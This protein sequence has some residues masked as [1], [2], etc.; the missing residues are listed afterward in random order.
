MELDKIDIGNR[1]R[2]IREEIYNETRQLFAERCR[3]NENHLGKIERGELIVSIKSLNKICSAT[4]ASADYILYG[5]N[6]NKNLKIRK[7]I[8]NFLD[9]SNKDELKMYFKFI[10]IIKSYLLKYDYK[11]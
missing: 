3:L 11:N 8:E 9:N 5:K 4:G 10:T 6:E 1:I 2:K 7:S